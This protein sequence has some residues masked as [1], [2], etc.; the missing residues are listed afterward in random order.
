MPQSYHNR[1]VL[2]N[3]ALSYCSNALLVVIHLHLDLHISEVNCHF[4]Q[5]C[6]FIQR[7]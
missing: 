3:N 2:I 1:T 5:R 7:K 4:Y 6:L